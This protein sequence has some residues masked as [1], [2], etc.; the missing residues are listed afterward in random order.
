MKTEKTAKQHLP[1]LELYVTV[2]LNEVM[3]AEW[4]LQYKIIHSW[5]GLKGNVETAQHGIFKI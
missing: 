2:S 5:K 1:C 4:I 3:Y